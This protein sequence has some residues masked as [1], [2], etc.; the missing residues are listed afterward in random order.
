MVVAV[1]ITGLRGDFIVVVGAVVS[2]EKLLIVV[3]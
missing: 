1:P 2:P 3:D